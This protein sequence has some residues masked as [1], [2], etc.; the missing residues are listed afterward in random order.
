[1]TVFARYGEVLR[2]HGTAVPLVASTVGRLSLGMTTFALLLLV[3]ETSG[4][5]AAA[6]LAS[7]AYALSFGLVGPVLARVADRVGPVRVLRALAVVHPLL[8]VV[9]VL[10][11]RAA[12]PVPWLLVPVVLAGATVPPVGPVMRALWASVL[13]GRSIVTAYSLES[14]VVELCFVLGP[15]LVTVLGLLG[16]ASAPVLA[17]ALLAGAGAAWLSATARVRDVRPARR[18][19][20]NRS[21]PLSSPTVRALLLTVLGVG[22]S[23]GAVEVAV[24]AFVEGQGGRA[25]SAG[26]LLAVWSTG[27]IV[28]GLLYGGLHLRAAP[29]QQLP[30]LVAA[31]A[32]GTAAPLAVDGS[33][34]LGVALFAFGLTIA[35]V[36]ACNAVLLSAAT[37]TGTV[38]EVFAWNTSMIFGGAALASVLAGVL[39][40]R[41]GPTGA[42]VLVAGCGA[43]ALVAATAAW[44]RSRGVLRT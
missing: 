1:M 20:A 6:G 43:L 40:E 32:V 22:A 5:D 26:V 27:S 23:F 4:S 39:V 11:S 18:E 8:L 29:S 34:S 10:A 9:V 44:W 42:L 14:V 12:A 15:L 30:V 36:T 31:L 16:G 7:G 3:R 35:P 33:V 19:A 17:S 37:P 13:D 25:A 24:P 21:G 41:Y 2:G 28:G 38:T